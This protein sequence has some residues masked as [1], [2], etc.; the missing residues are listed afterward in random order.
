[1]LDGHALCIGDFDALGSGTFFFGLFR[2]AFIFGSHCRHE[3]LFA[4]DGALVSW[5]G[6]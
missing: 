2:L 6:L 3:G 4:R 1:M 5:V